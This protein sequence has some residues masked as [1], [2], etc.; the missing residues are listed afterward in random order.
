MA[1]FGTIIG[2]EGFKEALAGELSKNV[3]VVAY[4]TTEEEAKAK[5]LNLFKEETLHGDTRLD[6]DTVEV[7]EVE[8]WE[9]GTP[10]VV[11]W[12]VEANGTDWDTVVFLD[13]IAEMDGYNY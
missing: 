5:A 9:N 12:E 4:V 1:A 8:A 10:T 11:G 7:Y 2:R 13:A 3:T 6:E